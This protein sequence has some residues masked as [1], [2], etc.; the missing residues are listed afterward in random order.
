LDYLEQTTESIALRFPDCRIL[1]AGDFNQLSDL[2]IQCRTGLTRSITGPTRGTKVL[3]CVYF[4]C[5]TGYS[6]IKIVKSTIKS[7]HDAVIVY[8]NNM[9]I[10]NCNKQSKQITFRKK[11]PAV[12]AC[13][14]GTVPANCMDEVLQI[15][16]P[17]LASDK[18]YELTRNLLNTYYPVTSI[19]VTNK[20][21]EFM[22]GEIK[23]M[24]RKKMS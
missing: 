11:S 1:L 17:Q 22:T 19:T 7:D 8:S 9:S 6:N 14:L 12:N 16:D 5:N 18:F 23:N 24:L 20:D 21:P 4:S 10:V 13:F 2:D 3:D 15:S